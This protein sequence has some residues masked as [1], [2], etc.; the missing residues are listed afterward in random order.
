MIQTTTNEDGW[1]IILNNGAAAPT[2]LLIFKSKCVLT[3]DGK[4]GI[5]TDN[6]ETKLHLSFGQL[7]IKGTGEGGPYLYRDG[8]LVLTNSIY[9]DSRGTIASPTANQF[10]LKK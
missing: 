10:I 6:P 9:D 5:G 8:G 1:F 4:V 2:Q 3:H 7:T